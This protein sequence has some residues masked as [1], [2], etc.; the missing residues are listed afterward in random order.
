MSCLKDAGEL[1]TGDPVFCGS[2]QAAFNKHSRID[3]VPEGELTLQ[4]WTCEFC[5]H[6][7]PVQLEPEERPQTEAVNYI[8][9][10]AAQIQSKQGQAQDVSVVF[11]V[12][13]SGSMCVTQAVA[14][15]HRIKGDRM[16]GMHKDL[17]KFS[18]GS[19]QR[20][21]GDHGVTYVSRL[22]CVQSAIDAQL[23]AMQKNNPGRKIGLVTFNSEVTVIGDGTKD[24]LVVAGDKLSNHDF[25]LQNG[26]TCAG[27]LLQK[28]I[29]ETKP[30]LQQ[31]LMTLEETGPTALGPGVLTAIAL[32]GEG[33]PGSTVIVCTDGLANVGLGSFDE[34]Q[35]EE[36][37]LRVEAFYETIGQYAKT[38]GV[39]VNVVSIEGDECNIDTLSKIAELTGGDVQR[40]DPKNLIDNFS[41]ILSLPTIAT[42]VQLKVKLHKGLEFR[43]EDPQSLSED[44]TI[45][46]RD[47]GNVNEDTEVTFEY[48]MKSIK[49]LLKMLDLDMSKLTRFPFQAQISY[50]ALDGARC[51]RV[52]TNQVETSSDRE[53]L[54]QGANFGMLGQAAIQQSAKLARGGHVERA[55]VVA[56]AWHNHLQRGARDMDQVY[57]VQNYEGNMQDMYSHM[58]NQRH[59]TMQTS[60]LMQPPPGLTG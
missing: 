57:A 32:A 6:K 50:T 60:A 41:N 12:D 36:Q 3:E 52:I 18:D 17:M 34:T 23:E 49:K 40:V 22:Q 29:K 31:K 20:L 55:Q 43:N 10:A 59:Q 28:S 1:A 21:Q 30:H 4:I 45:L 19:D 39:T 26:V 9:E 53:E 14:G 2:C 47:L 35:S 38:K 24:P 33:A 13:T 25:L 5:L 51:V 16:T 56:K 7:N 58:N 54:V 8:L 27:T 44:M 11:C 48:K 37:A 46:A 42:N 15:R